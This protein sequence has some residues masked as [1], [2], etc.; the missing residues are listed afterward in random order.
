ME[1][2]KVKK[3][4][5]TLYNQGLAASMYDAIGKAKSILNVKLTKQDQKETQKTESVKPDRFSKQDYDVKKENVSLNEL[6]QEVGVTPEQVEEQEKV[7]I[8]KIKEEIEE[9]KEEIKEADDDPE[10]T[11]HIEQEVSEV[12]EEISEIMEERGI[13]S[14]EQVME[15]TEESGQQPKE[16][17]EE[18]SDTKEN[19][20]T[21]EEKDDTSPKEDKKENSSEKQNIDL[22]KVF[23]YNK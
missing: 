17:I 22:T 19:P 5:E 9:I 7:K 1:D 4:A 2:E 23:N 20:E 21:K 18:S 10:K 11:K 14:K 16:E 8:D 3:L 12:N 6:M 15:K 13:E